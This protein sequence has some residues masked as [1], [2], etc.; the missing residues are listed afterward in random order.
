MSLHINAPQ[1]PIVIDLSLICDSG[2]GCEWKLLSAIHRENK[3]LEIPNKKNPKTKTHRQTGSKM[4]ETADGRTTDQ[5]S[6]KEGRTMFRH[7]WEQSGQSGVK[8]KST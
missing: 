2:N 3:R 5:Q 6:S 1:G 7:R 8:G 4:D